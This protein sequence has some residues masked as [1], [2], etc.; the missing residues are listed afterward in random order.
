[1]SAGDNLTGA[2]SQHEDLI[3][4]WDMLHRMFEVGDQHQNEL[5]QSIVSLWR[6]NY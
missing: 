1:M 5:A 3:D 6:K 4:L 2:V